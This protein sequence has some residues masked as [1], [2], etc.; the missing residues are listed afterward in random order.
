MNIS[1]ID[2]RTWAG[3][4]SLTAVLSATLFAVLASSSMTPQASARDKNCSDF[5]SQKAA[6]RWFHKHNP[7]RDPAGL[8]ADNDGRACEDNP[9]PCTHHRWKAAAP[10]AARPVVLGSR[11]S[12]N[13][14]EEPALGKARV[15][16]AS[17]HWR[18]C[19]DG[20]PH[21]NYFNLKAD[22]L[23]CHYAHRVADHHF[24]TADRR[25]HG[26]RCHDKMQYESGKAHC[27]RRHGGRFQ[28]LR[29]LFGV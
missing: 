19:G 2:L 29:Y 26:W 12:R 9:C 1:R 10:V 22:N 7:H 23:G 3:V 11:S 5:G 4:L 6:Q 18:S 8:D 27:Q 25:F 17:S 24:H 13:A 28:E 21:Y 16:A 20:Y 14:G 15:V